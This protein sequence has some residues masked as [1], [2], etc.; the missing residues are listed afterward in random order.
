MWKKIRSNRDPRDTLYSELQKE[1]GT[2][3]AMAANWVRH[4]TAAHPRLFFGGMMGILAL[5]FILSFT[6]FREAGQPVPKVTRQMNPV[7]D[8]FDRILQATGQIRETLRLKHL[9]DSLSARKALSARDS[10]LLDSALDRL[11][12]THP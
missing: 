7:H 3:F 10:M 12:L 9:V 5:S 1:F 4:I 11:F 2:Y 8:G 6:V